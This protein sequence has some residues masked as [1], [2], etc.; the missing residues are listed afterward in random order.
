MMTEEFTIYLVTGATGRQGGAVV[1]ELLARGCH[2]H[3][4]TRDPGSAGAQ[5]L[6]GL[7]AELVTGD[8]NDPASLREACRGVYGVFS[9]QDVWEH[10]AEAEVVQGIALADAA[11][12]AGVGHFIY[13]SVGGAERDSGLPHFESKWRV[14]QHIREIG[15]PA[16][17]LRPVFFMEN[18]DLPQLRSAILGGTLPLALSPT[19]PLQMIAVRD[20]GAMAG[21]AFD[22]PEEFVG[23]EIELAGDELTMPEAAEVFSRVTGRPV[24]FEQTPIE[25]LR[26][27]SGEYAA[28]F[29]WFER[30][31]YRADIGRLREL[32]PPLMTLEDWLLATRWAGPVGAVAAG[33][34]AEQS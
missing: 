32:Y 31:G 7:G 23:R 2:V 8:L 25:E 24:R 33:P 12:E 3:A 13:T 18:F 20:I 15:L 10:G 1:R 26:G 19:T 30:E 6:D 16:T 17:V 9:V 34:G 28:M 22:R 11:K 4:M 29:E 14:E 21:I 5:A 27:K